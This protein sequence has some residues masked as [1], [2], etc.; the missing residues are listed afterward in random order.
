M[1]LEKYVVVFEDVIEPIDD[2]PALHANPDKV[3]SIDESFKKAFVQYIQNVNI[4]GHD[5]FSC[6]IHDQLSAFPEKESQFVAVCNIHNEPQLLMLK[7][8]KD[9]IELKTSACL[10]L[11]NHILFD[12]AMKEDT[13]K[14]NNFV[15][16]FNVFKQKET[17]SEA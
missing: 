12:Y 15:A 16:Y 9:V 13:V 17:E 10:I 8:T 14:K 3:R 6:E 11:P 1:D 4:E 2:I 5:S 7:T